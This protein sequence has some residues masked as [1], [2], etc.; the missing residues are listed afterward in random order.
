MKESISILRI[1]LKDLMT[2]ILVFKKKMNVIYFMYII[3]YF[4]FVS[5]YNSVRTTC[6]DF[7]FEFNGGEVILTQQG[8][9]IYSI[10][11]FY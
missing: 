10:I 1:E 11:F 7:N 5:M 8:L 4:F 3:G 2:I 9:T 6:N